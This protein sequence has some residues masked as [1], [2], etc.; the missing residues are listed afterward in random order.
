MYANKQAIQ[1]TAGRMTARETENA[2]TMLCSRDRH[3]AHG[4]RVGSGRT[5]HLSLAD[6]DDRE[7]LAVAVSAQLA[8]RDARV[9]QRHLPRKDGAAER[10][11]REKQ[12]A[13]KKARSKI[14]VS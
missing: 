3:S 4:R 13:Q 12:K 11:E 7:H 9:Q 6:H 2:M 1:N 10:E 14:C 8:V 5:A